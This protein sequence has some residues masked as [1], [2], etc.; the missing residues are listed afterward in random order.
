MSCEGCLWIIVLR[1]TLQA[2]QYTQHGDSR[3]YN[4][5]KTL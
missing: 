1:T 5:E 3:P 4:A 2:Y